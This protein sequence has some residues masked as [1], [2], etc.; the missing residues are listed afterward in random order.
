MKS[1]LRYA[2]SFVEVH[3]SLVVV[4]G[5][6]CF[7]AC[8]ISVPL[9]RTESASSALQGRFLATRPPGKSL[10]LLKVIFHLHTALDASHKF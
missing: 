6:R 7:L 1:L 4:H 5:L 3:D 8:G 9:P 10:V 2:G